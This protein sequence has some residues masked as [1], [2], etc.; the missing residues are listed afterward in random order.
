MEGFV[1]QS[2]KEVRVKFY[3][4]VY[5]PDDLHPF[6]GEFEALREANGINKLYLREKGKLGHDMPLAVAVVKTGIEIDKEIDDEISSGAW[7]R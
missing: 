5:G 1:G 4:H 6:E 2:C 7:H 3:V